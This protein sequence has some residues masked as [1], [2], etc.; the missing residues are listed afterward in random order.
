VKFVDE[1]TIQVVAG[2]GGDGCLSFRHEK[3]IPRGGPDG[4]DGGDGG[5][6][7]LLADAALNTLVDFRYQRS[8]RAERGAN[9]SGAE[10]TGRSGEDLHLRVPVGTAAFDVE[11]EELLGDITHAGQSLCVARG[12]FHGLGNARF[13]SSVNRAPRQTTP[14]TPGDTRLIRL[15]LRLL[16]DVGL[17]GLPNAGKSSLLR[18]VTAAHPK[19]AAYPFTTLHP[20]LGVVRLG[21]DQS[22]VLADLPGLIDGAAQGAGLGGHFLKH[23]SRTRLLLHLVDIAPPEGNPVTDVMRIERELSLYNPELAQRA[24]WLVLNKADLF[25]EGTAR[26]IFTR[27]IHELNWTQPAF[28]ISSVNG[29]G[30]QELM[31]D[32]MQYLSA[33]RTGF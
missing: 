26:E 22:F 17:L 25:P 15:E 16:A 21:V 29:L 19:V 32:I 3:F 27:I 23:L 2:D 4:G 11:T 12:G 30:C 9:G 10:C 33:N 14:G 24:R 20:H 1:V 5:S 7:Y 28:L 18:K 8:F 13:K 31:L 6:V